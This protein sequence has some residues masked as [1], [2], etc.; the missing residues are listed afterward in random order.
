[1]L[2]FSIWNQT[3]EPFESLESVEPLEPFTRM[4]IFGTYGKSD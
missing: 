1:M 3:L 4:L 2:S